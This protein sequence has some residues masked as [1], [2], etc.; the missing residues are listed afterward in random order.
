[1]SKRKTKDLKSNILRVCA[2]YLL[3]SSKHK[4]TLP[5]IRENHRPNDCAA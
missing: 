3:D 2:K 1:M 5:L 4:V